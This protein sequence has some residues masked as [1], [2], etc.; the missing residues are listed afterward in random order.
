MIIL[1]TLRTIPLGNIWILL[2]ENWCGSLLRLK[3]LIQTPGCYGQFALSLR[4]AHTLSLNSTC[5]IQT[6]VN[7]DNRHLFEALIFFRLL[8]SN[9]LNWKIY[10]D[11]HSSLSSTTAV[12][13]WIISYTSHQTL[14]SCPTNTFIWKV[15]LTYADTLLSTVCSNKPSLSQGKKPCSWQHVN[16]PSASVHQIGWFVD[17]KFRLFWHQTSYAKN[18]LDWF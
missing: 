14:V 10:C 8:F 11:D 7:A 9:C 6:P 13:K 16:V 12:Q 3:G 1:L 5:F 2:G 17:V 15:N 18:N 4:K